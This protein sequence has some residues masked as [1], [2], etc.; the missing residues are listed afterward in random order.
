MVKKF[1]KENTLLNQEFTS[2]LLGM[3]A[4]RTIKPRKK[5]KGLGRLGGAHRDKSKYTRK[6]KHRGK[7]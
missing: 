3:K 2:I 1:L 7:R 5:T 6:E 4:K